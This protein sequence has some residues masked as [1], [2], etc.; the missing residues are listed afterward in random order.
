MEIQY[1]LNKELR[2]HN[3]NKKKTLNISIRRLSSFFILQCLLYGSMAFIK[4][5]RKC[6]ILKLDQLFFIFICKKRYS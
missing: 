6:A 1:A 3:Y 2:L 5:T 4:V